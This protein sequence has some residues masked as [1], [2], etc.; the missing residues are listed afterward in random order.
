MSLHNNHLTKSI[1]NS[2]IQSLLILTPQFQQKEFLYLWWSGLDLSSH[3]VLY[4]VEDLQSLFSL[5]YNRALWRLGIQSFH[6]KLFCFSLHPLKQ[7]KITFHVLALSN[8]KTLLKVS[9]QQSLCAWSS[10][11]AFSRFCQSLHTYEQ[12]VTATLK[13]MRKT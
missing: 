4:W 13:R 9:R 3:L 1:V 6:T 2:S 5:S 10:T 8:W 11:F 12:V 7:H